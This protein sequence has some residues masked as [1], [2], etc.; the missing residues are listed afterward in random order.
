M[1]AAGLVMRQ[2]NILLT[3]LFFTNYF[4]NH[5]IHRL[6]LLNI[7]YLTFIRN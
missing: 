7:V 6:L 3:E 1:Y 5:R 2:V 4:V